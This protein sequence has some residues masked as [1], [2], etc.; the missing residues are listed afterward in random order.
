MGNIAGLDAFENKESLVPAIKFLERPAIYLITVTI[1]LSPFTKHVSARLNKPVSLLIEQV[2]KLRFH[3]CCL[4]KMIPY[5][6]IGTA[7]S[8]G[9]IDA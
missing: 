5:R 6:S 1:R 9:C 4:E 2:S 8:C 3:V 7:R